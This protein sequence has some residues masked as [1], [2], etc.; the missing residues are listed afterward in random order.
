[1]IKLISSIFL[2]VLWVASYDAFTNLDL[3]STETK[4]LISFLTGVA[5]YFVYFILFTHTKVHLQ[6][7]K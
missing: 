4:C 5:L 3:Q 6:F 7:N 2:F 1:M